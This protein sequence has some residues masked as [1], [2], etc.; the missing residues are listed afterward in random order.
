MPMAHRGGCGLRVLG[1]AVCAAVVR[2]PRSALMRASTAGSSAPG[3]QRS[4]VRPACRTSRPG[5]CR[6]S[7]RQRMRPVRAS[8]P[9]SRFSQPVSAVARN[10]ACI[11]ARLMRGSPEGRWR[12]AAPCLACLKHSSMSWWR[13]QCSRAVACAGVA[14]PGPRVG[15]DRL[16]VVADPADDQPGA[17]ANRSRDSR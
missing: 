15:A 17:A 14:A 7:R 13:C 4:I 10:A 16:G 9:S 11:Q 5:V 6:S 12:G 3:G 8:P 2:R 1:S